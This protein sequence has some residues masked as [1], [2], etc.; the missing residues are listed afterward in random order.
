MDA[1][2][3]TELK[4]MSVKPESIALHEQIFKT[5]ENLCGTVGKHPAYDTA[6]A[7]AIKLLLEDIPF[8]IGV[9]ELFLIQTYCAHGPR[10]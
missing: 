6:L 4:L 3:E 9:F 1:D 5:I 2:Y 10:Y 7:A 8:Y